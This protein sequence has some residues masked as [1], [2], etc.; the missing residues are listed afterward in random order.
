MKRVILASLV[1]L[2]TVGSLPAHAQAV[3]R[4]FLQ[5]V[6]YS[7]LFREL[8][9]YGLSQAAPFLPPLPSLTPGVTGSTNPSTIL[10]DSSVRGNIDRTT[11]NL[12][13][14]D[15]IMKGLLAKHK[16]TS[17]TKT[18]EKPAVSDERFLALMKTGREKLVARE[19]EAA[20]AAFQAA[21]KLKS[22]PDALLGLQE[23]VHGLF[24]SQLPKQSEKKPAPEKKN[25]KIKEDPKAPVLP[26]SGEV[27]VE[28][29]L[30]ER[31][32][33]GLMLVVNKAG[34]VTGNGGVILQGETKGFVLVTTKDA[35]AGAIDIEI[36]I[37]GT[38][39]LPTTATI[40]AKVQ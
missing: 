31:A 15:D 5:R 26:K 38:A 36:S 25:V 9:N 22:D 1:A 19:F 32:P 4:P 20:K 7:P 13:E 27:K 29:E 23:A 35:A 11:K 12:A 40:K 28:V 6:I 8:V 33:G 30:Q 24:T 34:P 16:L 10:V 18:D 3:R 14:A 39:I 2:F 37:I 21:F 17:E